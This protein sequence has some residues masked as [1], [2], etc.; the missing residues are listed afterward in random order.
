MV[1]IGNFNC[2][3]VSINTFSASLK[4]NPINGI[5]M[6]DDNKIA[7]PDADK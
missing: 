5:E 6:M 3:N 1:I 7:V 2:F 4:V